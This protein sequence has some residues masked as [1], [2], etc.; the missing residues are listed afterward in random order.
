MVVYLLLA[1]VP[2]KVKQEA[3]AKIKTFL[4]NYAQGQQGDK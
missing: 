3:L 4:V 2:E 1:Q